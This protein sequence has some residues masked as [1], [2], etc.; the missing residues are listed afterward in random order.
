MNKEL[1]A[2]G[3]NTLA[4]SDTREVEDVTWC[5][6]DVV[7]IS[8]YIYHGTSLFKVYTGK[9]SKYIISKL[10]IQLYFFSLLF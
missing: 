1:E 10:E 2:L 3:V 8:K 4:R 7:N 6:S 9:W 5:T